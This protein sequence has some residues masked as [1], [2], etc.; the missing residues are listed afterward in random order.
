[1]CNHLVNRKAS[2]KGS[3]RIFSAF[4]GSSLGIFDLACL[5][6]HVRFQLPRV[7]HRK[8]HWMC[9]KMDWIFFSPRK[10]SVERGL[11][12]FIKYTSNILTFFFISCLLSI[13]SSTSW[14]PDRF[15][16]TN[17]FIRWK[18]FNL[19]KYVKII[20]PVPSEYTFNIVITCN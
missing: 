2:F 20:L 5:R 15:W 1:M 11:K 7:F 10:Y 4:L 19:N 13:A 3:I 17:F 6:S 14:L 18:A 8:N 12:T 16:Y 9:I